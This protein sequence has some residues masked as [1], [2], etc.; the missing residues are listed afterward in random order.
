MQ[1]LSRLWDTGAAL[2]PSGVLELVIGE[3][4]TRIQD[5]HLVDLEMVYDRPSKSPVAGAL[6]V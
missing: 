3:F 2:S 1:F 6:G 5:P 4:L